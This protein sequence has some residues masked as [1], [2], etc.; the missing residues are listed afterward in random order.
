MGDINV[1]VIE[2]LNGSTQLC[3]EYVRTA[4]VQPITGLSYLQPITGLSCVL[5]ITELSYVHPITGLS[6]YRLSHA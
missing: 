2:E 1:K 5:L 3:D 4:Y 6:V